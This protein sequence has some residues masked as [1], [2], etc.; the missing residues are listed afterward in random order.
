MKIE[1]TEQEVFD[2]LNAW[3]RP[4][5]VEVRLCSKEDKQYGHLGDYYIY[6]IDE[7]LNENVV[8]RW[9]DIESHAK[10]FHVISPNTR[11][12]RANVKK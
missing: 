7:D 12:I 4:Q 10:R 5:G 8:E 6:N 2:R 3:L 9:I 11:M 1:L